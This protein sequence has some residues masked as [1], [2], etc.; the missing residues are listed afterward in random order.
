M[1]VGFEPTALGFETWRQHVPAESPF[2][3]TLLIVCTIKIHVRD[4][5]YDYTFASHVTDALNK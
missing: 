3:S 4:D 5:L 2:E 1:V